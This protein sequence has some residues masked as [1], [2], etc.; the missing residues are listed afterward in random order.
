MLDP[1]HDDDVLALLHVRADPDDQ[2]GIGVEAAPATAPRGAYGTSVGDGYAPGVISPSV[3]NLVA[4]LTR[5][6]GIGTRTAQRLAFHILRASSDEAV[7]LVGRDRRGQGARPLLQRVR[8]PHRGRD[9]RD[10]PRRAPRPH[11]HL[12]RRAAGRRRLARADGRVPRAVP[13]ARRR[14]LAARR[15]R[16]GRPAHRRADPPR[17]VERRRRGRARHQPEHDRRGDGRLPRRPA[18]RQGARHAARERPP[19]RRRPRVRRRGHARARA[20][21]APRD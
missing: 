20:V 12:R 14:A 1:A 3:D 2:V 19:G 6:P 13:R 15:R 18:A 17:R 5:L 10:L 7:A 4:Q 11:G 21:R 8:Q 9:V 16:P